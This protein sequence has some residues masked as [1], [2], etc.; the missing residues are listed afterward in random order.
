MEVLAG[1]EARALLEQ[2][3]DDL[4]RRAG[5]RGRLEH[6]ELTGLQPL[7]DVPDRARDD[8]EVRLAL[9]R[10]RRRERDQDRVG[11]A[12]LVVVRRR[13]DPPLLDERRERLGRDVL[14][15]ARALVDPVDDALLDVD[16]DDVVAG[17]CEDL[18]Q[19]QADVARPDDCH[20]AHDAPRL[21]RRAATTCSEACPSP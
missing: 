1:L 8:R 4:A 17:L 3:L 5:I 7:C 11:V 10:Q 13:A 20:G 9:L 2:R 16:Q 21:A 12:E 14:D 19:R 15:V 6:D 18:R